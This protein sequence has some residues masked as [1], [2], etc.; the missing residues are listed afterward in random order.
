[1]WEIP[2]IFGHKFIICSHFLTVLTPQAYPERAR[3]AVS[4]FL[5]SGSAGQGFLVK[6]K[7]ELNWLLNV[8]VQA[9]WIPF[10]RRFRMPKPPHKTPV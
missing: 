7:L 5:R 9:F 3:T 2:N 10:V 8:E 1:M 6:N 4:P